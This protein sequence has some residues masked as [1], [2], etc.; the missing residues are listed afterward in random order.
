MTTAGKTG[1]Y[2]MEV[3]E[4]G[5]KPIKEEDRVFV[6]ATVKPEIL[7]KLLMILH[8][9]VASGELTDKKIKFTVD[10]AL[11]NGGGIYIKFNDKEE[12]V[13]FSLE[14]LVEGAMA[15]RDKLK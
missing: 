2:M 5:K 15:L 1:R 3:T 11:S 9:R 8:E 4:I 12:Q 14:T 10:W 6:E 13:K 7:P